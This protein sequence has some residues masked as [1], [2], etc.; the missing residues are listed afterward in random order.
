[1][2]R[3]TSQ[4]ERRPSRSSRTTHTLPELIDRSVRSRSKNAIPNGPALYSSAPQPS[5][6]RPLGDPSLKGAR[7]MSRTVK[8]G[9]IQ[10]STPR[11]DGSV[12]EITQAMTEK[13]LGY[14]HQ[15]GKA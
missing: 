14:V 13:T 1:M 5:A 11:S 8:G 2:A 10:L 6:S 9:L 12:K 4:I 3:V 15:A 7:P